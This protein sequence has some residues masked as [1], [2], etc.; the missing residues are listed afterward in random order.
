MKLF[1]I[2]SPQKITSLNTCYPKL[3]RC[4]PGNGGDKI[5]D[6]PGRTWPIIKVCGANPSDTK[7]L[8]V[9]G[10]GQEKNI[11]LNCKEVTACNGQISASCD[12]SSI[13]KSN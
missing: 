2:N 8:V 3:L 4:R 1:L 11:I 7:W 6:I 13:F 5:C 9:G 12:V 10:S